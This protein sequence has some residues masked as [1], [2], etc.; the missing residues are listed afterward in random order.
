MVGFD[1][2]QGAARAKGMALSEIVV[3]V[4]VMLVRRRSGQMTGLYRI[5][6]GET[7]HLVAETDYGHVGFPLFCPH[8]GARLDV[9]GKVYPGVP[10]ILCLAHGITYSLA[11]GTCIENLGAKGEDVGILR[12]FPAKRD[13]HKFIIT[14]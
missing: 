6:V 11:Y 2:S 7:H 9:T 12:T 8:K 4:P 5:Q 13:G 3:P 10:A 14:L 1:Q